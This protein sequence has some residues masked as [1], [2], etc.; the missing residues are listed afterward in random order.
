VLYS[1]IQLHTV[2]YSAIQCY[3]ALYS[4]IQCYTALYSAIQCYT[5]LYSAKQ[6]YTALYS[7]MQCYTALYSAVLYSAIQRY[8]APSPSRTE[9][10]RSVQ[11]SLP[12]AQIR[13]VGQDILEYRCWTDSPL[14]E[15]NLESQIFTDSKLIRRPNNRNCLASKNNIFCSFSPQ[16]LP[17]RTGPQEKPRPTKPFRA[18]SQLFKGNARKP[19]CNRT[20]LFL[21]PMNS[22]SIVI[23]ARFGSHRA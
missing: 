4:S 19:F 15:P 3:T 6:C 17:L 5:A 16:R 20:L 11:L 8:T 7:V 22:N 14:K 18:F 13:I 10:P 21:I 12:H 9:W 1:S 23:T 2:L